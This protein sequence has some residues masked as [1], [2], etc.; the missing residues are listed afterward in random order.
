MK[1]IT[2]CGSLRFEKEM[3]YYA[4]KLEFERNCVLSII[5]LTKEKE[6]YTKEEI[7]HLGNAHF[8]KIELADAIFVVNKNGYIGD[9]VKNEIE[10]AKKHNKE[11]M[12]LENINKEKMV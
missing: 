11:I 6:K 9:A 12:Y 10:F 1:I 5:Y 8:K 4:E 7:K 2:M 3:I